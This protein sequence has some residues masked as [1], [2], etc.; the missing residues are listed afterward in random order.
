MEFVDAEILIPDEKTEAGRIYTDNELV[1]VADETI[2][3][4][5]VLSLLD[6]DTL[7]DVTATDCVG[8]ADFFVVNCIGGV[9]RFRGRVVLFDNFLKREDFKQL[10][11]DT[12]LY[13]WP[14]FKGSL[15]END[16]VEYAELKALFVGL[17]PSQQNI[18]PFCTKRELLDCNV[19]KGVSNA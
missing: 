16:E 12:P 18:K 7:P 15:N 19:W 9:E 3:P 2:A 8:V 10:A 14:W 5:V 11:D 13:V 1:E 17:K 6:E 4:V